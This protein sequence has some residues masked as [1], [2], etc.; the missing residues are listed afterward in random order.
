MLH[1]SSNG[2]AS[3]H[4]LRTGSNKCNNRR[5]HFDKA[6]FVGESGNVEEASCLFERGKDAAPTLLTSLQSTK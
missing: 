1:R 6:C 2:A 5:W 4:A 3:I